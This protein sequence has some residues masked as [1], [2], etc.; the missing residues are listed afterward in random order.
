[1]EAGTTGTNGYALQT[2][3]ANVAAN[4]IVLRLRDG[5]SKPANSLPSAFR[6]KVLFTGIPSRY[7]NAGLGIWLFVSKGNN[8]F[9]LKT[10][11]GESMHSPGG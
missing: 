8:V 4:N 9:K 11:N 10:A 7:H 3:V 5:T 6:K 2:P 1:M